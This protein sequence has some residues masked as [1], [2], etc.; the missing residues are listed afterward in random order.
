MRAF[1]DAMFRINIQGTLAIV[2]W[3]SMMVGTL[4]TWKVG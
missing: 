1:R 3:M 2:P 4:A